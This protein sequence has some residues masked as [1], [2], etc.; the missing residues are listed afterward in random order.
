L[1]EGTY[2]IVARDPESGAMGVAVQSH[3]FS[4]GALVSWAEAGVGAVATQANVEVA[5]GPLGLERLRGGE[6]AKAAL[7]ALVAAD[8]QASSRQV[9]IVDASGE[10]A[11]HTGAECMPFA[12]HVLG[13]GHSC[14]ANVMA[15]ET[16]W[17]AM[18]EAFAA[19]SGDLSYRLLDALDAGEG[20]GGDLRGRQ[21]AAILVVPGQGERWERTL[22]LRVEDHPDPLAELRRLVELHAAYALADQ[23]DQLAAEGNHARAAE[24]YVDAYRKAPD[25]VEL[26]F[27]AGLSLIQ[28]G[29]RERGLAHLRSTFERGPGWRELLD[30]LGPSLSPAAAEARRLLDV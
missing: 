4:V 8:P 12:G 18:S 1:S 5:Y 9:A 24:R 15:G 22:E 20:A 25:Y 21:S 30:R 16:V 19:S 17:P 6:S 26:E 2:S 11:A 23:G 29:D 10:V 3:W 7:A 13:E 28:V 27:W 14:Q